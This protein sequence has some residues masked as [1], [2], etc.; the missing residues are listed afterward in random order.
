MASTKAGLYV[1][2][3]LAEYFLPNLDSTYCCVTLEL[4]SFCLVGLI[5]MT[6]QFKFCTVVSGCWCMAACKTQIYFDVAHLFVSGN[7]QFGPQ[8][9]R[10]FFFFFF[11][12]TVALC[13]CL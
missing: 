2:L 9:T 4:T 10:F 5:A 3:L 8:D 13:N 6:T 7:S 11:P 1:A 12:G